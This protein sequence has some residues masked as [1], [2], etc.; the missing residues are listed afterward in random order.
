MS[1]A[2]DKLRSFTEAR[3]GQPRTAHAITTDE[4]LKFQKAH[5]LA[6]D[7]V[8]SVWDWE[9]TAKLLEA[10]GESTLLTPSAAR[11]RAEFLKRPDLGRRLAAPLA[12]VAQEISFIVSDGLSSK[13]ISDHFVPFWKMFSERARQRG[14]SWSRLVLAPYGRVA[15]SDEIGGISSSKLAIIF[16]G[17]RPGLTANDSMGIYL[18]Y[19][20]KSG[21]T[22]ARRNCVSNIRPPSGLSYAAAAGKLLY[23]ME[24]SLRLKLSGVDLKE[25]APESIASKT[26]SDYFPQTRKDT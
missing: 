10:F 21:T 17:E 18:T 6:R 26:E 8:S 25:D 2:W 14:F 12:P 3:I 1:N 13:A 5:A 7:A 24:E 16:V 15:I 11:D 19:D 9:K 20:P 22:D 4:L 23:L